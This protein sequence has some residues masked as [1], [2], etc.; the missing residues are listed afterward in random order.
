[1]RIA[2]LIA[3]CTVLVPTLALA[4]SVSQIDIA[5][6][7]QREDV[8]PRQ[9]VAFAEGVTALADIEYSNLLG[10][11][12]LLLDLY[13]PKAGVT[14]PLVIWIHGGGWSRGD[15]RGNGAITNFPAAL[16]ELAARGYVVASVNYRLSGEAKF[17]A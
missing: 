16:A 15:S 10:Y 7:T 5:P 2:R 17:P 8:F 13:I 6:K 14:H 1:M 3:L 11:R 4:A 9:P 12:P